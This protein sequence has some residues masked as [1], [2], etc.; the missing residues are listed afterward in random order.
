MEGESRSWNGQGLTSWRDKNYLISC[1]LIPCIGLGLL[2]YC[3]MGLEESGSVFDTDPSIFLASWLGRGLFPL[4]LVVA[5]NAAPLSRKVARVTL[6]LATVAVGVGGWATTVSWPDGVELLSTLGAF[7]GLSGIGWLYVCWGEVYRH[8]RIRDVALST[9]LS[10]PLS[11]ILSLAISG[12]PAW[13]KVVCVFVL[14]VVVVGLFFFFE[15]KEYPPVRYRAVLAGYHDR[16]SVAVIGKLALMLALYSVI[17]GAIHVVS[18][19]SPNEY[20][21]DALYLVYTGTS[22]FLSLAFILSVV[23]LGRLVSVKGFWMV[24][25]SAICVSLVLAIA[26]KDMLQV[27]L[28]VFAAIRYVAFG[29]INI[30]LVDLAHHSRVPVYVVFAVGWGIIELSMTLG[31][32]VTLYAFESMGSTVDVVVIMLLAALAMG[33]LF[34]LNGST[35]SDVFVGGSHQATGER[36]EHE[37]V[38]DALIRNCQKLAARYRLTER[39]A[40]IVLLIAQGHTQTY[41]AEALVVSINTIRS[42]MKHIYSKMEIHSKDEL[43]NALNEVEE[44]T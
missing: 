1:V 6:P 42:H 40:E 30:K 22:I 11:S 20:G 4:I 29:F 37:S 23:T 24:T 3:V 14:S 33:S 35:L 18:S 7:V 39:E 21:D 10:F 36:A 16:Q 43:L 12:V 19:A 8:Q 9:M 41:C 34:L 13:M 15:N 25:V 38:H 32:S 44:V 26:F 5:L 2:R 31:A 28:A 17:L 27:V